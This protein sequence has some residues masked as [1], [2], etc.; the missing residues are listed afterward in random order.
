MVPP[1]D[2]D[3]EVV[4]LF[5]IVDENN[6]WYLDRNIRTYTGQSGLVEKDDEE[7]T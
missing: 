2:V 7:G 1:K 3:R 6:R 4:T 5:K